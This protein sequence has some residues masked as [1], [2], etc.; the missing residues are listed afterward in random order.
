MH[1]KHVFY[2]IIAY[3]MVGQLGETIYLP[4]M[5]HLMRIFHTNEMHVQLIL[6]A[7]MTAFGLSHFIYGPL[8]DHFGRRPVVLISLLG[9]IGSAILATCAWSIYVLIFASFSM[10][11][12]IGAAGLMARTAVRDLY[13]GAALHKATAA[14]GVAVV[15]VPMVAPVLGA[16]LYVYLGW[17]AIFGFFLLSG[18]VIFLSMWHHF[19]ETNRYL[20]QGKFKLKRVKDDYHKILHSRTFLSYTICGT[21]NVAMMMVYEIAAPFI[22]QETMG[23]SVT[24]YAWISLMPVLGFLFGAKL[25]S[26]LASAIGLRRAVVLGNLLSFP[27]V[28]A[29]LYYGCVGPLTL[30]TVMIPLELVWI[31]SGILFSLTMAGALMPFSTEAGVAGAVLGGLTNLVAGISTAVAS[32][33][34]DLSVQNLACIFLGACVASLVSAMLVPNEAGV[35]S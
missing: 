16:Y 30:W 24:S 13:S 6:S 4:V 2:L 15:F 1:T 7:F 28:F 27:G 20:G 33:S 32:Y 17:R 21:I 35:L 3:L 23:Y 10:G 18:L 14:V 11:A 5:P 22:F 12:T 29:L 19:P 26:P 31:G 25:S 8:S 34:G 9:F